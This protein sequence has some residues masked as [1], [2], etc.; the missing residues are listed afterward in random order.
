MTFGLCGSL[1][2]R[3][4]QFLPV[5]WKYTEAVRTTPL[6]RSAKDAE[7]VHGNRFHLEANRHG[8]E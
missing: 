4:R 5:G 6:L 7:S 8:M 1:L 2:H 3:G